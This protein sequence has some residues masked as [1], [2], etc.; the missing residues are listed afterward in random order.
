MELE[1]PAVCVASCRVCNKCLT[2]SQTEF[3]CWYGEK[4]KILLIL[5]LTRPRNSY[6]TLGKSFHL[7]IAPHPVGIK[8]ILGKNPNSYH[9]W[10]DSKFDSVTKFFSASIHM[11]HFQPLHHLRPGSAV[12]YPDCISPHSN[13]LPFQSG[14]ISH[15]PTSLKFFFP[16]C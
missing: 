16:Q 4:I 15:P 14:T 1:L 8:G 3:N 6:V 10:F 12:S 11:I 13:T 5:F 2:S 9:I 7:S